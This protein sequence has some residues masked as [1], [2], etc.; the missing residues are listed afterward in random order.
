M[1]RSSASKRYAYRDGAMVEITGE[2][3]Y[4]SPFGTTIGFPRT[5]AML[6]SPM[7]FFDFARPPEKYPHHLPLHRPPQQNL[8]RAVDELLEAWALAGTLDEIEENLRA[9]RD[10]RRAQ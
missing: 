10:A 3:E 9:V 6:G 8:E 1:S 7:P 4:V 5:F 2:A